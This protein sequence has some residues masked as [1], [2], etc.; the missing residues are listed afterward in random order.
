MAL[1]SCLGLYGH[2]RDTPKFSIMI[3][4]DVS[5]S[6]NADVI[7][8]GLSIPQEILE[9]DLDV[10]IKVV[11]Y[12]TKIHRRYFLKRGQKPDPKVLG[13][14]G[15]DFDCFFA[16]AKAG[17]DPSGK[18]FKPDLIINYTDGGA[19]M[20]SEELRVSPRQLPLLWV[21]T[22]CGS[23]PYDHD[24]FGRVLQMSKR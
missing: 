1:G 10:E 18:V 6:M 16:E 23:A 19:P 5:G 11:E 4:I 7:S 14:G 13:R 9:S 3:G 2:D 21:I 17:V 22:A 8:Y 20:P 15:T 12:D 24:G